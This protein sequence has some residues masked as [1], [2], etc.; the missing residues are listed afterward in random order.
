MACSIAIFRLLINGPLAKTPSLT[1]LYET[2]LSS[3]GHFLSSFTAFFFF[4]FLGLLLWHTEVPR[5]G[6]ELEL[7]PPAYTTATATPDLS[8]VCNLHHSSWQ[9]WILTTLSKARDRTHYLMVP[10]Q[11]CFRWRELLTAS[12]FVFCHFLSYSCSIWRFAD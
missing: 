2:V 9:Q 11:I 8:L 10:S 7:E 4:G 12:P 3:K 5:L 6:V 1:T